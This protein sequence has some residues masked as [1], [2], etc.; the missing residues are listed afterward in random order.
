METVDYL[1]SFI[2]LHIMGNILYE[3]L[4]ILCDV[5]SGK[6]SDLYSL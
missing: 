1:S 3:K 6:I 2:D 5:L 4:P